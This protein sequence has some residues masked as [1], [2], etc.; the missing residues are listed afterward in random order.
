MAYK[1]GHLTGRDQSRIQ[2]FALGYLQFSEE[3]DQSDRFFEIKKLLHYILRG[4]DGKLYEAAYPSIE[5]D[6]PDVIPGHTYGVE[7]LEGLE[8]LI[9]RMGT[10]RSS[11]QAAL[12][13][14]GD[15]WSE[16]R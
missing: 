9:T 8:K 7:D 15:E 13:G 14:D 2:R 12:N 11:T 3:R 10:L 5:V 4:T 16:W 6:D 1:S